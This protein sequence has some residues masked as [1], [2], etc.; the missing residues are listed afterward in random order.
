MESNI[1]GLFSK[2]CVLYFNCSFTF[3]DGFTDTMR[4]VISNER[5]FRL[6]VQVYL[7][8]WELIKM[9]DNGGAPCGAAWVNCLYNLFFTTNQL[10]DMPLRN[11]SARF[12]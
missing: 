9:L 1:H 2:T 12:L 6:N 11:K 4:E 3:Y 5:N 8:V 7:F 10:L